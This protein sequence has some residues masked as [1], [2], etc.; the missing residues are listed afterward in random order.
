MQGKIL[1][2][3]QICTYRQISST[4]ADRQRERDDS[5]LRL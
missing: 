3:A 1:T 2:H 5:Y 4:Y